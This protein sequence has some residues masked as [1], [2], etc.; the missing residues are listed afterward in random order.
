[1]HHRM[2]QRNRHAS[3]HAVKVLVFAVAMLASMSPPLR[4]DGPRRAI[5][6]LETLAVKGRAPKTGYSRE[7]FGPRWSDVD[8]NGCD[9]RNDILRR[10]LRDIE[11]KPRKRSRKDP[12]RNRDCVVLSGVLDD[13]YSG[14]VVPFVRGEGSSNAVHIDHVVAKGNAWVTGAFQWNDEQRRM[15]ANDPLNLLAVSGGLNSKKRDGDAAT[16]LPPDRSFRCRYVARQI[17][18]K[19][20]YGLWVT[21]PEKEAMQRILRNCPGESLP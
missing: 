13:P 11:T 20:R 1:M 12:T 15:F 8:R 10:D 16:W 17:A 6:V 4:A 2:M 5:E 9:T 18:V 3:S 14:R 19:Q 7:A 21:R